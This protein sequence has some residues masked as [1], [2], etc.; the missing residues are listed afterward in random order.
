ML[1][2]VIQKNSL[3]EI[4]ALLGRL[5]ASLFDLLELRLDACRDL[6]ADG[7]ADL[8]L[9][10][11]AIFT[12]RRREE[13]GLY[14]GDEASRLALLEDLIRLQPAYMDIEAAVPAQRLEAIRALSPKT[15]IILSW[16]DFEKT[17]EDLEPVLGLMRAR[18]DGVI[19]KVAGRARNTLD[20]LRMLVFCKEQRDAGL[21]LIGI[22]MGPDG[23]STRILAPVVHTGLCYCP[24]EE[25]SA[26][27]QL[28]AHT[29]RDVYRFPGLNRNTALYGLIGNPVDRSV[30]HLHHNRLNAASGCDA[31]YVKWRLEPAE[32]DA[33]MPLLQRLG[34]RGLSVTMPLK[35][36]VMPFL[37]SQDDAVRHIGAA[38]TLTATSGGWRGGSTDG[39]GALACLPLDVAG[40]KIVVLGAGGAAKSVMYEAVRRGASVRVY[41][42]TPGKALPIDA[43]ALPFSALEELRSDPYDV[44]VNALPFD[45]DFSFET[46]PFLAGAVAMDCSYGK[47]GAFLE[48]AGRA[49]CLTVDGAGMFTAQ[50]ALQRA[51]WGLPGS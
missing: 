13:G 6:S 44:I 29:L 42:R 4:R 12:L 37:A 23:E 26:P 43:P 2:G 27:G 48:L 17:P 46:V 40:K 7:V 50:A 22:C 31:V 8:P 24:V 25:A 49:G 39:A 11:P 14:Q 47:P 5:D 33:A 16:H 10:L 19:Y 18:A 28:D 15:R 36:A 3:A 32:L 35:E 51:S 30:G 41:N 45:A 34:V 21:A 9:P 38:N 1:I 20:A